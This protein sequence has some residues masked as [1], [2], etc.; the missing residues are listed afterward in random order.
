MLTCGGEVR[1]VEVML[2]ASGSFDSVRRKSA[3]DFAQ[4]DGAGGGV[5]E[6]VGSRGLDWQEYLCRS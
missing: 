5:K 6:R 3:T 1:T 2:A 4:D